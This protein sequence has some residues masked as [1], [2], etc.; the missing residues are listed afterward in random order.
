M[1]DGM[2]MVGEAKLVRHL[3]VSQVATECDWAM[4]QVYV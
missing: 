1:E 4:Y 2:S 3:I